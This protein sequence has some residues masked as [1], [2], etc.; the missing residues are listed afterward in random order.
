[1]VVKVV[2][3]TIY[4]GDVTPSALDTETNV[5]DIAA[6]AEI[7]MIE[8]YIDL[9]NLASG[10]TELVAEYISGDGTNLRKYAENSYSGAQST[11]ILRFHTKT[12]KGPYRVTIKQTG[13][14]LRTV[15]YWFVRE[16]MEVT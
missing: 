1:M 5:V 12:T 7:Y 15:P 3:R 10:D 2:S 11:P 4:T 14:T 8:G 16:Q 6:Q 13:G 9:V